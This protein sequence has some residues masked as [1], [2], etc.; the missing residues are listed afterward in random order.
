MATIVDMLDGRSTGAAITLLDLA[1]RQTGPKPVKTTY[2]PTTPLPEPTRIGTGTVWIDDYSLLDVGTKFTGR[3]FSPNTGAP[4]GEA[5][6][7]ADNGPTPVGP[8]ACHGQRL[9][10]SPYRW[11]AGFPMVVP[12]TGER[13]R[14]AVLREEKDGRELFSFHFLPAVT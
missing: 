2:Q 3:L 5:V 11:W 10:A 7:A 4:I 1:G 8:C 13:L 12:A 6:I 9:F 14:G